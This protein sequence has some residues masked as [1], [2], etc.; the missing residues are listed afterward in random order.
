MVVALPKFRKETARAEIARL[1]KEETHKVELLDHALERM[2]Q[3]SISLRQ[4]FR[5][6]VDG[7]Q[8]SI[9]WDDA[10]EKGWRCKLSCM[11]AGN[12]ITVVAKLIERE[13]SVCLVVTTWEG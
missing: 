6:L 11:T 12:M 5:T 8:A 10:Q 4:V 9:E 13:G 1:A 2:E 7:E 3:R